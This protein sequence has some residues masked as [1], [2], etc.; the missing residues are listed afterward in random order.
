PPPLTPCAAADGLTIPAYL[1]LPKGRDAK[2]LPLVVL[3]HGAVDG[4]DALGF[5][6]LAQALAS[7]GY[8]VLQ[9]QFRGSNSVDQAFRERGY[10]E[11]GAKM[12]TDLSDGVHYLAAQG[13]ID[14]KRVCIVGET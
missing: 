2:A 7:R 11:W 8:A 9:P 13:V 6:W 14:P 4:H 10:G 5:N 12:R 3:P 1:T